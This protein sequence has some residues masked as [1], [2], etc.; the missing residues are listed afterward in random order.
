MASSHPLTYYYPTRKP[1]NKSKMDP[2]SVLK[3]T[4]YNRFLECNKSAFTIPP[5]NGFPVTTPYRPNSELTWIYP[6]NKGFRKY[7]F[8]ICRTCL[9]YN[10]LVC[11]PTGLG[12]TFIAATVMYNYYRWFKEGTVFFLAPTKPLVDQQYNSFSEII[13]GFEESHLGQVT[14]KQSKTER[15]KLYSIARIFFMTPQTLAND[16]KN[17][18]IDKTKVVCVVFDEAHRAT[19]NYAYCNIIKELLSSQ[20]GYRVIALS[21]T[22]G[23]NIDTIQDIITNLCISKIEVRS[24]DDVDVKP[25]THTK[26]FEIIRIRKTS[27]INKLEELMTKVVAIPQLHLQR[28]HM[29]PFTKDN[30]ILNKMVVLDAQTNLKKNHSKYERTHTASEL[31]MA[32]TNFSSMLSLL[33]GLNM[34]LTH[35]IESLRAFCYKFRDSANTKKGRK[36]IVNTKQFKDVLEYLNNPGTD[37]ETR[38]KLEKV[39]DLMTN[40]FKQEEHKNSQAIIFTLFVNSAQ[41][42]CKYLEEIDVVSPKVFIG[43]ANGFSQKDQ[44]RII[45]SFKSHEFNTLVATCIGEEGLDIGY[46]DYI[47]S[48]DCTGSPIRMI[49]RFGR[50]GRRQEGKVVLLLCDDEEKKYNRMKKTSQS[51]YKIL[52]ESS[53]LNSKNVFSFYDLNPRMIRDGVVPSCVYTKNKFD[54]KESIGSLQTVLNQIKETSIETK[55]PLNDTTDKDINEDKHSIISEDSIIDLVSDLFS[56]NKNDPLCI[57]NLSENSLDSKRSEHDE[58]NKRFKLME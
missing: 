42:I 31:S 50:T 12:K 14:G 27:E 26:E 29:L 45:N 2:D 46:V 21:A 37:H 10:T 25:Y 34:L 33:G 8:V 52:K 4:D 6:G 13:T 49:Q 55:I 41:E 24:E 18:L 36:A 28:I 15:R 54:F 48:Y 38:P 39:K 20:T 44:M 16:L 43:Q 56:D 3:D 9:F 35:G 30:K 17:E 32:Y 1:T 22:P 7:Q 5:N 11:L 58:V 47:I 40:F 19:G 23:S 51:I 53:R 57:E